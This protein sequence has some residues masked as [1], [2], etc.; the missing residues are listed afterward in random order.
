MV[1]M[2]EKGEKADV[3]FHT[4]QEPEVMKPF[5]FCRDAGTGENRLYLLQSGDT[6]KGSSLPDETRLPGRRGVGI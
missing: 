6:G 5:I 1:S 4:R 2:A 3:V